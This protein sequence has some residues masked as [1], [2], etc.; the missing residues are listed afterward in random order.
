LA[1]VDQECQARLN[2][3]NL[4]AVRNGIGA[5]LRARYIAADD[6]PPDRIAELV[7]ELEW[8]PGGQANP[9]RT[10]NA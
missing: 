6:P 3:R 9:E 1:P 2:R 10:D 8:G 4:R 7:R 5:A